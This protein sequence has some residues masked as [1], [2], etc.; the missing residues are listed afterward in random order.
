MVTRQPTSDEIAQ[1]VAYLP[2][3]Y[4]TDFQ[5][6]VRWNGGTRNQ[7]G[8]IQ[9]PWPVYDPLTIEFFRLLGTDCW[10]DYGYD[11][12]AASQMLKADDLVEQASLEQI[13]TMLT[14]CVR[15]ERFADGHWEEMIARGYIHRLLTRLKELQKQY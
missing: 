3:L 5:P 4:A 7:D 6:V 11:P 15:G 8:T 9:M 2:R 14:F 1:L 13:K 12:L 10:L